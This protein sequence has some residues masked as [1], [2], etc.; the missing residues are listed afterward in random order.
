MGKT[1]KFVPVN[2]NSL[3]KVIIDH[4]LLLQDTR[5]RTGSTS[6][7][8][9]ANVRKPSKLVSN[10]SVPNFGKEISVTMHTIQSHNYNVIMLI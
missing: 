6:T 3:K 5:T 9:M 10:K 8:D 1:L 4:L 2:N 7:L